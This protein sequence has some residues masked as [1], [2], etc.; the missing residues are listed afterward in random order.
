MSKEFTTDKFSISAT[1]KPETNFAIESAPH[2][3]ASAATAFA[4]FTQYQQYNT[5][6]AKTAAISLLNAYA[7]VNV[8]NGN[9]QYGNFFGW[10]AGG[11]LVGVSLPGVLKDGN[12]LDTALA[13]LGGCQFGISTLKVWDGY[14]LNIKRNK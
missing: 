1:K 9:L 12:S 3:I 2:L 11:A 14:K 4:A 8:W 6:F 10:L 13:T 5:S 7:G